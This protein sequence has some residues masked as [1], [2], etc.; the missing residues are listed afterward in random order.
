MVLPEVSLIETKSL[1]LIY[2]DDLSLVADIKVKV[3]S[4]YHYKVGVNF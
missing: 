4:L 1:L 3:K 2:A